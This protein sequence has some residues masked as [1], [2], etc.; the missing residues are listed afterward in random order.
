MTC[1]KFV[2]YS[3]L[4]LRRLVGNSWVTWRAAWL[5]YVGDTN[6]VLY[7]RTTHILGKN[8]EFIFRAVQRLI[9][10]DHFK[11]T[12]INVE[13]PLSVRKL[14][15]GIF[16][17][18]LLFWFGQ[19]RECRSQRSLHVSVV[20]ENRHVLRMVLRTTPPLGYTW[21]GWRMPRLSILRIT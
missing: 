6:M 4:I 20:M 7:P 14:T 1:N 17:I 9:R 13:C 3:F 19:V 8:P 5:T 2:S 18:I 16:S 21:I 15:E 10:P 11:S 12:F